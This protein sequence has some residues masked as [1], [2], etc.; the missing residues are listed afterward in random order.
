MP[1]I[2][3]NCEPLLFIYIMQNSLSR[4]EIRGD[5]EL[6]STEPVPR[7]YRIASCF[8]QR[9]DPENGG[10]SCP[11]PGGEF[12]GC[13]EMILEQ[14]KKGIRSEPRMTSTTEYRFRWKSLVGDKGKGERGDQDDRSVMCFGPLPSVREQSGSR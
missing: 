9:I 2:L 4:V 14:R 11:N 10:R 8:W 7:G 6:I 1:Y 12:I 5:L 3:S 13:C